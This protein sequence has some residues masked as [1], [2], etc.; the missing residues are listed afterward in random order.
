MASKLLEFI[1]AD[2]LHGNFL[3]CLIQVPMAEAYPVGTTI[4]KL[5]GSGAN[6]GS[7]LRQIKSQTQTKS[8]EN[9]HSARFNI[10]I[11]CNQKEIE[12]R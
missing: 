9:N 7:L 6:G 1:E 12:E 10:Q 8:G 5:P 2:Y 3:S 4:F 11:C